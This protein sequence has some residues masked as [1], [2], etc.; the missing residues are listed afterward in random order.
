[1]CKAGCQVEWSMLKC[2]RIQSGTGWNTP[3]LDPEATERQW[4]KYNT[5]LEVIA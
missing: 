1:M 5:I 4:K 3:L 2:L